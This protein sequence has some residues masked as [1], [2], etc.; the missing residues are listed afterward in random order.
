M[1]QIQPNP[2]TSPLDLK[3]R[4]KSSGMMAMHGPG[5]QRASE[6]E[7]EERAKEMQEL[8]GESSGDSIKII[9]YFF[10]MKFY[11]FFAIH[12]KV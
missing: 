12:I 1:S 4:F 10:V 2:D 7:G 3:I 8:T 5:R 6:Q 11:F 9:Y